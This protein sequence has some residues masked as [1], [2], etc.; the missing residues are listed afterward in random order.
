[1][2]Y[3]TEDDGRWKAFVPFGILASLVLLFIFLYLAGLLWFAAE[4]AL[5]GIWLAII[6]LLFIG[7]IL[8]IFLGPYYFFKPHTVHTYGSFRLEDQKE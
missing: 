5:A 4:A 3:P 1:M 2:Q 6:G 7:F 8:M